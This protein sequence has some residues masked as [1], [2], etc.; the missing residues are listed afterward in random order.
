MPSDQ[1]DLFYV[2]KQNMQKSIDQL[3]SN[4][5]QWEH[6]PSDTG[7]QVNLRRKLLA[8]CE[9]IGWQVDSLGKA[10]AVQARN[11]AC[12][13]IDELEVEKRRKWISTA[14][15]QVSAVTKAVEVVKESNGTGI[16][17]VNGMHREVMRLENSHQTNRSNQYTAQD[18]ENFIASES[19]KQFLFIKQQD[20]EL[21]E[22]SA[23]VAR[24]GGVGLTVRKVFLGQ[25][26]IKD[27]LGVE[28]SSSHHK[29][30]RHEAY[31]PTSKDGLDRDINKTAASVVIESKPSSSNSAQPSSADIMDTLQ[32]ILR[33][34][35]TILR[36]QDTITTHLAQINSRLDRLESRGPPPGYH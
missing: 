22:V 34:Q 27:D 9:G 23:G 16:T 20:K 15:T 17:S 35:D 26:K 8:L 24:I 5:H 13:G 3:Q 28:L 14:R 19:D 11:P 10:I 1:E 30:T 6:I 2:F 25:E 7:E 4:F 21:K 29:R 18:G 33:H 36:S 12:Y 32:C 31:A